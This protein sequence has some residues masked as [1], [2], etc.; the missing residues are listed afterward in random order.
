MIR[1]VLTLLAALVFAVGVLKI[2]SYS[3]QHFER[4]PLV[5]GGMYGLILLM[6]GTIAG[7]FAAAAG[8]SQW[9]IIGCLVIVCGALAARVVIDGHASQARLRSEQRNE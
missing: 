3:S 7:S 8:A 9:A 2:Y 6:S 1:D 4:R 5:N